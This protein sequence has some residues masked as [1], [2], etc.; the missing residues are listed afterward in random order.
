MAKPI[1]IVAALAALWSAVAGAQ[2]RLNGDQLA[3]RQLHPDCVFPDL[4][5]NPDFRI[6]G[7]HFLGEP[8]IV[9]VKGDR[10]YM[11]VKVQDFDG[12][13][14]SEQEPYPAAV[15]LDSAWLNVEP[16]FSFNTVNRRW[17]P[18]WE[19]PDRQGSHSLSISVHAYAR[20]TAGRPVVRWYDPIVRVPWPSLGAYAEGGECRTGPIICAPIDRVNDWLARSAAIH[21]CASVDECL[22]AYPWFYGSNPSR[23][24]S[25]TNEQVARV[26]RVIQLRIVNDACNVGLSAQ[27]P[28]DYV[29]LR[30]R[31][32]GRISGSCEP[33]PPGRGLYG[34]RPGPYGD[35]ACWYPDH[36]RGR[37]LC[38][39]QPE[40]EGYRP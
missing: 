21:G 14:Y 9:V 31:E 29:V 38:I 7:R 1:L 30:L 33:R 36:D 32:D 12:E 25:L 28:S 22:A 11:S 6:C 10:N 35:S 40:P 15:L 2:A 5:N 8:G 3:Y 23:S 27:A 18:D 24:W 13:P 20:D 16:Y 19:P 4:Q 26:A 37:N 34:D 17:P 39:G